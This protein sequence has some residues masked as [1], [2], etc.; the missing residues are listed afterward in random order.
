MISPTMR[1]R[2]KIT[3]AEPQYRFPAIFHIPSDGGASSQS[4]TRSSE[5]L[6]DQNGMDEVSIWSIK[7]APNKQP[8]F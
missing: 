7:W 8:I 2:S 3:P 5:F 6:V 4:H 1:F